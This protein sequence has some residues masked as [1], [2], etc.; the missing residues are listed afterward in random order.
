MGCSH[1][2]VFVGSAIPKNPQLQN[3]FG[4]PQFD[5]FGDS[6]EFFNSDV[7]VPLIRMQAEGQSS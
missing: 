7:V 4:V 1:S 3:V 6:R 2:N 5:V